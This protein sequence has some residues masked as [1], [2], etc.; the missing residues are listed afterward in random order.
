VLDP[1]GATIPGATIEVSGSNLPRP[2]FWK[3]DATGNYLIPN[4]PIGTYSMTISAPGFLSMQETE[5]NV[6]IGR[7]TRLDFK[8]QIG[9]PAETI[10]VTADSVTIDTT[11]SSSAVTIDRSF[12]DQIPKG[13]SFY[14]LTGLAPGARDEAKAGGFQVDGA[15][16]AE[17]IFYVDGMEITSIRTGTLTTQNR[18][19]VEAIQQVQV[20]N[21]VMDAQYGGA[22]GGVVNAVVRSGTNS[23]HGQA[24]FYYNNDSMSAR[25]RPSLRLS[26][27]DLNVGK[28]F[29]NPMDAY[30]TWNPVFSVGGPI[31]KDKLFFFTGYMPTRTTTNRTVNFNTGETGNYTSTSTQHYLSNKLDFVPASRWTISASWIWNPVKNEGVLPA[32]GGTDAYNTP[33]SQRGDYAPGNIISG[34]VNYIPS[35]KMVASF[36]GGYNYTNYNNNYGIPHQTAIAY[37]NSNLTIP[38]IPDDLRKPAGWVVQAIPR[39]DYDVYRRIN[40][41]ADVSY[42]V[43]WRGQHNLK[44]GWQ[45]NRL[46]NATFSSSYPDGFY[47]YAWNLS[48]RCVTS[49]CSGQ[50][51]GTW[52]YYRYQFYATSGDAGGDNM[53]LFLQDTWTINKHVTLNLGLRT[54][55]ERLPDFTAANLQITVK[56]IEFSWGEKLA[57]RLGFAYDPKGDGKMKIYGSWSYFYDLMKYELPRDYFGGRNVVVYVYTLEDP[58]WVNQLRGIPADP[59]KLPGRFLEWLNNSAPATAVTSKY[60]DPNLKPMKQST[61]DLGFDY[62]LRSNLVLSLRYTDR[63][64]IRT[65]EDIGTVGPIGESYRIGNPG[66]GFVTDPATWDPGVPTTPKAKR[67]YDALEVRLDRRFSRKYQFAVSYTYSRIYGNYGGLASSDE[68]GR[69]N[70][71]VERY[72]D[73]PWIGYTEK[74]VFSEGRLASDRPNTLKLFGTYTLN[75]K[76]GSTTLSPTM[77]W[78]SGTPLTTEAT[79]KTVSAPAYIYGRGDLG[80]TPQFFRADVNLMHDFRPFKGKE[81]MKVRFEFTV[82][83]LFNSATV[84]NRD[85]GLVHP[86]DQYIQFQN[87]ADIFKGFN[88]RDLM[89]QQNIRVNPTYNWASEFM[90]P[91]SLRLQVGFF[92]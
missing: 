2:I 75:S 36:R 52:G 39:T 7:T 31:L 89:K 63:R 8:M 80:R 74:G 56:T 66:F 44:G 27:F 23:F 61:F 47:G 73:M 88:T 22:M 10:T 17:N 54:E 42:I 38:G 83:N 85:V 21:G 35:S 76:L 4:V 11:A 70:P 40:L 26:P 55:R 6:I 5:V 14:D 84:V 49:Q 79:L 19:P 51:R 64:L 12:F 25:L 24:G 53:G 77:A 32:R 20:K 60:I 62:S 87:T 50:Q 65:I 59:T 82:F 37:G 13:R 45:M 69:A 28:Y 46:S 86:A 3:S 34:Q 81:N 92:F 57:P 68:N 18:I 71:N 72:F 58:N 43:N 78:Y 30:T 33:W 67:N 9:S 29:Q 48:Y 1:S 90:G 15:S 16:G 91:R 41:N